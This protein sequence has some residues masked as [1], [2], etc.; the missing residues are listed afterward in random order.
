[1]FYMHCPICLIYRTTMIAVVVLGTIV[2]VECSNCKRT[3][4]TIAAATEADVLGF[5]IASYRKVSVSGSDPPDFPRPV[6]AII[7][8]YATR[9]FS[10][11]CSSLG[12]AL[13]WSPILCSSVHISYIIAR[14]YRGLSRKFPGC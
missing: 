1:M 5:V 12:V 13:S 14:N 9:S 10:S 11:N 3:G 4:V 7:V 6:F 2:Q 8:F